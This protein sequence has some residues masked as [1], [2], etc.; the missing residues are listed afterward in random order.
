MRTL[1]ATI[2]VTD[3][4]NQKDK[5]GCLTKGVINTTDITR[6][7]KPSEFTEYLNLYFNITN[8]SDTPAEV[9]IWVGNGNS[10][11]RKDI[12]ESKIAIDANLTY[13]RGP[14]TISKDEIIFI[15]T[16]NPN[17][18]YRLYGYDERSF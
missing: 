11:E 18:V 12:L 13:V 3:Q 15:Q 4:N 17:I 2:K 10:P 9:T 1:G 7:F 16:N 5:Y 14:V 8:D 6:V